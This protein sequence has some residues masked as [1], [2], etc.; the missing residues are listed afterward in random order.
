MSRIPS[1]I[2]DLISYLRLHVPLPTPTSPTYYAGAG[3]RNL[4]PPLMDLAARLGAKLAKAGYT[5]R[6]G[7]ATG[8]DSAFEAGAALGGGHAE[9]YLPNPSFLSRR[10]R[11]TTEG[12]EETKRYIEAINS[13]PSFN[14]S[15]FNSPSS[16]AVSL[17]QAR[18]LHQTGP[19]AF[20]NNLS[21]RN[22]HM[23]LGPNPPHSPRSSFL[24]ALPLPKH[25]KIHGGGTRSAMHLAH[26]LNIPTFDFTN[27]LQHNHPFSPTHPLPHLLPIT[28]PLP[29]TPSPALTSLL[30]NPPTP[31]PLPTSASSFISAPSRP[32]NSLNIGRSGIKSGL[33]GSPYHPLPGQELTG[34]TLPDFEAHLTKRLQDPSFRSEFLKLKGKPLWCPGCGPRGRNCEPGVCH[35]SIILK[36]LNELNP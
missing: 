7:A 22:M 27:A 13:T 30:K 18:G 33:F 3:S 26:D 10:L 1:L 29:T 11:S 5:G 35:G 8:A 24:I 19:Q 25:G 32:P 23:I 36:Y 12:F 21:S 20:L 34:A 4:P 14:P 6:F 17:A 28:D 15:I 16:Y 2:D 9:I 31:S